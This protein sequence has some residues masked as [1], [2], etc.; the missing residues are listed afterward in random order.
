MSLA[1]ILNPDFVKELLESFETICNTL[2]NMTRV[3][4][5]DSSRLRVRA[6]YLDDGYIRVRDTSASI[7]IL[8]ML[9]EFSWTFYNLAES[10]KLLS[11]LTGA[12]VPALKGSVFNTPV[13]ANT[14]IFSPAL[15][16]TYS[17]TAFRIYACFNASGVLTVRRTRSATTVSEQLNS[18]TALNANAA[19]MFDIVVESGET[20]NLQYS[21][22][23]TALKLA[24]LEV[25]SAIS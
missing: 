20:I 19:Y 24:V 5:D 22:S 6:E 8:E 1:E 18:G 14:D 11:D 4:F 7:D 3:G 13:T 17:P 10:N 15:S 12:L 23:A 9:K 25:P 16:P 21:A 2:Q